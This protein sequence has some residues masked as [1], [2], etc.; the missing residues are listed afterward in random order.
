MDSINEKLK[1]YDKQVSALNAQARREKDEKAEILKEQAKEIK[2]QADLTRGFLESIEA[3]KMHKKFLKDH[4]AAVQAL[5]D[6]QKK[7]KGSF[8]KI[9]KK[10]NI[11]KVR[12]TDRLIEI[13]LPEEVSSKVKGD[14]LLYE[15]LNISRNFSFVYRHK[16]III[17]LYY[18]SLEKHFIRYLVKLLNTL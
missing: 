10:L 13:E 8:E 6:L 18:K 1:E 15:S 3:Q 5:T 14:K 12:Q 2:A 4:T 16:C 17:T 11:T 7:N 9:A